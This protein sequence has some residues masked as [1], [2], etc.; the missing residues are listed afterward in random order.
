MQTSA[1]LG[2]DVGSVTTKGAVIHE[3]GEYIY[4]LMINT[5]GKPVNTV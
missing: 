4:T 2:I 1:F 5:A 3:K